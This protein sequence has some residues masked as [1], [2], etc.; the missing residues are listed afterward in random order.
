MDTAPSSIMNT[1]ELCEA[2]RNM[3]MGPFS[4]VTV[5]EWL[6][7]V[8]PPPLHRRGRQGR[9]HL[10][11]LDAVVA[12]LEKRK[13]VGNESVSV[14][15]SV[16]VQKARHLRIR[17]DQIALDT[18]PIEDVRVAW[19]A[20]CDQ[21]A[22]LCDEFIEPCWQDARHATTE[23]ELRDIV[24]RHIDGLLVRLSEMEMPIVPGTEGAGS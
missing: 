5:Q 9:S 12:W 3:G 21:A 18:I 11:E 20:V 10:F 17:G 24:R 16:F 8:D 6:A 14:Y 23:L 7:G 13:R 19:T 1:I 4:R 22:I 15:D 2:L